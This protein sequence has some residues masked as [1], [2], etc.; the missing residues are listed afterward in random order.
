M[1]LRRNSVSSV[2]TGSVSPASNG[3]LAP[4]VGVLPSPG[5]AFKVY[6]GAKGG[7][8]LSSAAGAVSETSLAAEKVGSTAT[9]DTSILASAFTI[10]MSRSTPTSHVPYPYPPVDA[11][12]RGNA[13]AVITCPTDDDVLLGRGGHSGQHLGNRWYLAAKDLMQ[14]EYF[15]SSKI[16]K[17]ALSQSLV[18]LVNRNWGGRFLR[19]MPT[20]GWY[21]VNNAT[22]HRKASQALRDKNTPAHR[23]AKRA[24]YG[25]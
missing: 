4:K 24:K 7:V 9:T 5:S 8:S 23:A 20:K 16:E 25:N 10:G 11:K 1:S 19:R 18:D 14:D 3:V 15:R 2:D 6:R 17:F 13:F 22:A 12:E 21:E